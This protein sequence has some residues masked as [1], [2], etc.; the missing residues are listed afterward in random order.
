MAVKTL[1]VLLDSADPVLIKKW[2]A[3]GKLPTIASML[4]R[5]AHRDI[6][7]LPG[8]G[9]SVF[10]ASLFTGVD[11]SFHGRYYKDQPRP[12]SYAVDIFDKHFRSPPFWK[13]LEEE[14]RKVVVFDAPEAPVAGLQKGIEI[15]D[16]LSHRRDGPPGSSPPDL[17]NDL[18]TRFG[19]DPLKGNANMAYRRGMSAEEVARLCSERTEQR[20]LAT[21]DILKSRDWDVYMVNYSEPHDIGHLV[22]HMH[23]GGESATGNADDNPLLRCYRD[24]DMAIGQL[25][26]LMESDGKAFIVLGPGM[27][28]RVTFN[29]FLP[30]I[31]RAFQGKQRKSTKRLLSDA[32][33]RLIVSGILPEHFSETLKKL[34]RQVANK[35]R[36]GAGLRYFALPNND[37]A[38]AV[39]I[40]LR[41]R[42]PDGLVE[43]GAEYDALCNEI[44]ER[45]MAIRDATGE[46]PI[47][48]EII[49]IRSDYDG[50]NLDLLPDLF[51]VWNRNAETASIRS[52]D[53]GTLENTE[54]GVRS[55][56]HTQLGMLISSEALSETIP[57]KLDPMGVS[58][59]LTAAI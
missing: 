49:K 20:T 31:L 53:I 40:S 36:H 12:P 17:I 30:E 2:A 52:P 43:P 48:S 47:V 3:E 18:M 46:H 51:V 27:E 22:W 29:S 4:E 59:L 13:R 57:P 55:G 28:P 37:N 11:P 25:L 38:G 6:E 5:G 54:F 15:Y 41:G 10:W 19:D 7:N 23:E 33:T 8:F 50:P 34:K 1:I 21:K 58:R 39:R 45:L 35:A 56:D 14:G 24:A 42:E 9:S 44:G 32:T 26:P 16:W